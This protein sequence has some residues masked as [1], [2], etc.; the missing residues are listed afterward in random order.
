MVRW[1]GGGTVLSGVTL[2]S[3]ESAGQAGI[4]ELVGIEARRRIHQLTSEKVLSTACEGN[5]NHGP[6][7][8]DELTAIQSG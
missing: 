7:V 8:E 5:F 2:S 6:K 1:D 3:A 4:I